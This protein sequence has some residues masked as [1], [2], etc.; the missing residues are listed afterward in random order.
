MQ[1]AGMDVKHS[2]HAKLAIDSRQQGQNTTVAVE[3]VGAMLFLLPDVS[4]DT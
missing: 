2:S 3:Q 1:A 4:C